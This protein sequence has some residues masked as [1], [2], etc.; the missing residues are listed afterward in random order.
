MT[1]KREV[2]AVPGG[3]GGPHTP[4]VMYPCDAA[5][6]RGATV[7]PLH[8]TGDPMDIPADKR[9]DWVT[10]QVRSELSGLS[11]PLLVGK[12]LGTHAA[13]L[14]AELDLPAVWVTP[15]IA[16]GKWYGD[17]VAEA[18]ARAT[19]PCL[20]IGGTADASWDGALARELS[21]HVF[22]AQG[23]DHGL[24]VTGPLAASMAVMA[25]VVTAVER[26][27]DEVVWPG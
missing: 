22:E 3:M 16:P 20:L 4:W 19:A 10:G 18:L 24:Y 1:E 23:A 6:A 11:H 2:L 26:F 8:W 21:P 13:I 14:A 5:A 27:L 15:L 12:S 7:H 25:E 17:R 9:A